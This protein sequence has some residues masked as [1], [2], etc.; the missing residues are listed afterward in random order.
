MSDAPR[1]RNPSFRALAAALGGAA[2]IF[3]SGLANAVLA[4]SSAVVFMYHRFGESDRSATNIR[5]EQFEA[6]IRELT[7]KRFNVVPLQEVVDATRAGRT[8]PDRTVAIT[9]DDAFLS[10][11]TEAWPRLRVVNFPFTLFVATDAID[12]GLR[13]YMNWNQ[14]RELAEA[15]VTIGSQTGSHLHMATAGKARNADELTRSQ[16]RFKTELGITPKLFAYPYG[17][18][19]AALKPII[20][21]AGFAAAFGQHSGVVHPGA[22]FFFLPRFAMNETYGDIGRFRLAA[23]AL[24]LAVSE[25]TPADPLLARNNNPPH[26]GFTVADKSIVSLARLACYASG[27]GKAQIER[28]GR[29]RIEIRMTRAFP[30]GRSRVNCTMPAGSGRWRWFGMQFFVPKS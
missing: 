12:R 25:I 4:D 5:I 3:V 9:I 15:G 29:R 17:E 19:A 14:I 13:S 23:N 6:H 28:L 22:N 16:A 2:T 20:K 21:N 10:V 26:F 30:T 8:L 27:Q 11:Y 1:L 7:R 24:P 18:Y